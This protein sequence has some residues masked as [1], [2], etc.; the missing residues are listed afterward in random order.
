MVVV[1]IAPQPPYALHTLVVDAVDAVESVDVEADV[2]ETV[3]GKWKSKSAEKVALYA[4]SEETET[5]FE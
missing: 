5:F 3:G 1:E 4:R 2:V